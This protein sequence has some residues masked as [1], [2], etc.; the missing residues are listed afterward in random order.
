MS[1]CKTC[2]NAIF[3]SK[4]GEYKCGLNGVTYENLFVCGNYIKGVPTMSKAN[5]DYDIL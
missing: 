1:R 4:W 5:E 2:A 3:N